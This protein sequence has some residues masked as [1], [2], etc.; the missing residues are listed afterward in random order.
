[1][2]SIIITIICIQSWIR[3]NIKND[4]T[5]DENGD[6]PGSF[7]YVYEITEEIQ[8][9]KIL[10]SL[11]IIQLFMNIMRYMTFSSKLSTFYEVLLKSMGDI[12]LFITM[13]FIILYIY[14]LIGNI[15]FGMTDNDF[16]NM[17]E[18]TLTVFMLI[19]GNRSVFQIDTYYDSIRTLYG[20]SLILTG[21]ILLNM[22][23]A[24]IGSH[25]FEYYLEQENIESNFLKLFIESYIGS[26]Q[27]K[28]PKPTDHFC[29]K[30][31]LH[32]K[33]YLIK[34]ASKLVVIDNNEEY[35][36]KFF[37]PDTDMLENE[38]RLTKPERILAMLTPYR[39]YNERE[40]V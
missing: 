10:S 1:M 8:F 17:S 6:A 33:N 14:A 20:I 27:I 26:D 15:V 18:S 21:V 39:M 30:A 36:S 19:I 2:G 32:I 9:Y 16:K 11:N 23:I 34:W 12:L 25:Y 13:F 4:F 5:I 28:E 31:A 38:I 29:K 22:Q 24:I 40:L 37:L 3:I 35:E 7:T